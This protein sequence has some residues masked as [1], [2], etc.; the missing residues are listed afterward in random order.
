MGDNS[1]KDIISNASSLII[2]PIVLGELISGY[3]QG[4]KSKNNKLEL[5]QFLDSPRVKILPITSDTAHFFS[6]VLITL[7]RKGRP[8]PTNDIWI[9]AQALEHGCVVCTFDKHFYEIDG[10]LVVNNLADLMVE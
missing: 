4:S 1:I 8:I 2:S 7:K 5:Q 9:A 10:L 6:Q 3:D